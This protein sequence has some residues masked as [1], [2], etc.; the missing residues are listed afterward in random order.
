MK[1]RKNE[2]R[3]ETLR[4]YLSPF[5][6]LCIL[7]F[8]G[9]EKDSIDPPIVEETLSVTAISVNNV[10]FPKGETTITVSVFEGNPITIKVISNAEQILVSA[11]S[12]TTSI[13]ENELFY[14]G[15]ITSDTIFSI[16]LI[17]GG[18]VEVRNA[19]VKVVYVIEEPIGSIIA[20]PSTERNPGDSTTICWSSENATSAILKINGKDTTVQ[21]NDSMTVVL[22][23]TTTY[24]ITFTNEIGSY[25]PPVLTINVIVI[26]K[27]YHLTHGGKH[28]V[29]WE[30]GYDWNSLDTIALPSNLA[31]EVTYFYSDGSY[32]AF[33]ISDGTL[34]GN[35]RWHWE[36]I[37][38]ETYLNWGGWFTKLVSI[39]AE[40]MVLSAE[41]GGNPPISR[42][43]F[44][45]LN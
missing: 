16:T 30:C 21:T 45:N 1:A 18:K 12:D 8:S 11:G 13:D 26:D 32:V 44:E 28:A 10:L 29:V 14:S 4:R 42:W 22:S 15:P 9:C 27:D 43:T 6:A 23:E 37:L 40:G 7:F 33:H 2:L 17:K 39:S 20:K 5:L 3:K 41:G 25:T 19:T 24:E 36:E 31:D 34:A 35:G 38:C